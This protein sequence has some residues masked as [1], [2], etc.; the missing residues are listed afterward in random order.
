VSTT[1]GR[2][3]GT[4]GT[5]P[6]SDLAAFEATSPSA[7]PAA[8]RQGAEAQD[9]PERPDVFD[10]LLDDDVERPPAGAVDVIRRG[11]RVSPELRQ[12][13][14]VTIGLALVGAFG[15][16]LIPVLT[17]QVIDRGL[18]GGEGD[19]DMSTVW[20]LA[21]VA[22]AVLVV[23]TIT[24]WMTRARLAR[25]AETA[26]A[27]LRRKVFDH[28]HRLSIAR[29][30]ENRRGVLVA[31]VTA[32]VEQLSLFFAWGGIAWIVSLTMMTAVAV[33]MAAYDWR[34]ASIAVVTAVPL[35]LLLKVLQRRILAAWDLVRTKLGDMLGAIGEAVSGAAVIRAYGVQQRTT[36]RVTEAIDEHQKAFVKAGFL[37]AV[38]FPANEVFSV[39]TVSAV[40]LTGLALGT[41]AGL[42]AGEMVAFLF[43]VGL[44]L[45]PI[46][47]FTEILDQTQTAVA[48]WRKVLDVLETP[49]EV[50]DPVQGTLLPDGPPPIAV[51]GVSYQYPGG[52]FALSDVDLFVR[53]GASVAL[54]GATGSGKST[55]AKLL[56]RLADPTSGRITV[57]GVDLREV[58]FADLR[59]KLV[60]VPQEGF[61]FE[62]SILEN[63]RFANPAATEAGVR[64]AFY[65]LGLDEWL[66]TLPHGLETQVGQRGDS[67]SVG[68]RQLVSLARA[69]VANP[70][71]LLLDEATS[72]VDPGTETRIA[73]ALES[74]SRGRTSIT[75]AHRLSTA[76]R[77]DHVFVLDHGRLV[78]EGT[79]AELL[80]RGGVYA[81][82]HASWMDVTAAG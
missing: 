44:F 64:L 56:V 76:E 29:H 54:V 55:L 62:G 4:A 11:L 33:T 16:V 10:V 49:I 37:G 6:A 59:S 66:D 65:E 5:M 57:H 7:A 39:F 18:G 14:G 52:A 81:G 36:E 13:L 23:T 60:L 72:A 74:L 3:D 43:L 82:L 71:C 12:G 21:G 50:A 75:I 69:Y 20:T 27:G 22:A 79:H 48:G 2:A 1:E 26:L 41:D 35:F 9:A 17:Q 67:L 73:R 78:E 53:A 45:E 63:V 51:E 61:L 80:A 46:A 32:D 34:L 77:A 30:T 42:S 31:R 15:R 47:E 28:I 19:V 68:E 38:L 70:T 58:P 25:S 8:R 24:N 40:V